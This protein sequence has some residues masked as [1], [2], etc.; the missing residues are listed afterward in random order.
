MNKSYALTDDQ[1]NKI[2]PLVEADTGRPSEQDYRNI[3][4]GIFY[5]EKTGCSWRDLPAIYGNNW[6]GV[7]HA[8]ERMVADGRWAKIKAI[9]EG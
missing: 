8:H 4:N 1:W 3:I 7:H 5:R 9:V 6:Q 2:K